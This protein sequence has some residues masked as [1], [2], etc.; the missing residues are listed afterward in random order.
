[1]TIEN[2]DKLSISALSFICKSD[3]K[4]V[5]FAAVPYLQAMHTL[6]AITDRYMHDSGKSIVGYFLSNAG[7]WRGEVAKQV[8]AELKRRLNA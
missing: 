4:K 6:N 5:Y 8:K 7:A 3:W 1:M 2:I